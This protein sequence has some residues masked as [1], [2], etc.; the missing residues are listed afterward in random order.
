MFLSSILLPVGMEEDIIVVCNPKFVG[1]FENEVFGIVD[2]ELVCCVIV[3]VIDELLVDSVVIIEGKLDELSDAIVLEE[4]DGDDIS[5]LIKFVDGLELVPVVVV[6]DD[7]L[8]LC[9]VSISVVCDV[10]ICVN[11][12]VDN[13]AMVSVETGYI[14][15]L[16][17]ILN[18]LVIGLIVDCEILIELV[19]VE[20]IVNNI[21]V[22]IVLMLNW[23]A[24]VSIS[25]VLVNVII[26]VDIDWSIFVLN[27]EEFIISVVLVDVSVLSLVAKIKE[28]R[29]VYIYIYIVIW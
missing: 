24:V 18:V 22:E 13:V 14:D 28:K 12:G 19:L 7:R 2:W 26:V 23:E 20:L 29:F 21:D 6:V 3:D 11:D 10:S 15:V 25:A 4:I 27:T 9:V 8:I 5:V 16:S 1:L 17:A